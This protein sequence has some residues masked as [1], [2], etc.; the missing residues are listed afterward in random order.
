[1]TL[2]DQ[3]DKWAKS[4]KTDSYSMSIGELVNMYREKEIIINPKYQRLFRWDISQQ[5]NFIESILLGIPLPPIYVYQN[6]DGIWNLIDGLQR[7]ST[8]FKFMG[9]LEGEEPEQLVKTKFLSELDGKIWDIQKNTDYGNTLT[10]A[11]RRFIKRAKIMVIIIDKASDGFAQY[12]MF[13]R[14]N[15][16]GTMLSEQEIRNCILI[17]KNE[18]TFSLFETLS[19]FPAFKAT[20]PISE[21]EITAQGLMELVVKYFVILY[22]D[23]NIRQSDNFHSF[24][25][26]EIINIIDKNIVNLEIEKNR[27]ERTFTLLHNILGTST[28]KAFNDDEN[29]FS[30]KVLVGAYEAVLSGL[31]ENLEYYEKNPKDLTDKIKSMYTQDDFVSTKN[32][33]VRAVNRIKQLFNFGTKYFANL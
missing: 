18:H 16:G 11:Q 7:L 28:F 8:L 23:F 30:G 14:L 21:K 4:V 15:T 20:L 33:G 3:I 5:S 13:Q 32:K 10:E 2:Q 19:D 6:E 17:M 24:L 29:R 9:L 31:R 1:M 25:T 12:E 26:D 27:F 22:S